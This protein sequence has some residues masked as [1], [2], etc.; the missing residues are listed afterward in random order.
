MDYNKRRKRVRPLL[1]LLAVLLISGMAF[2]AVSVP[3][4]MGQ[5]NATGGVLDLSDADFE[6]TIH[7]LNGEWEFYFGHLY[8]PGNFALGDPEGKALIDVPQTW[9]EQ[10]YPT[11]GFATYR[12]TLRTDEPELMLLVPEIPDA[13]TVFVN[14]RRVF[15]AGMVSDAGATVVSVR[16]ALIPFETEGGVAEIVVQ[17]SNEEW[18][19]SGI[20]YRIETGRPDVLQGDALLRRVVLAGF[21]GIAFAMFLYHMILFLHRRNEKVYLAFAVT[22]LIIVLRFSMETNGLVQMFLPNGMGASLVVLYLSLLPL[23]AAA[24]TLFTHAALR[25]PLKGR[26][27]IA[28]YILTLAVPAVVPFIVPYPGPY[29]YASLIPLA[30]VTVSAVRSKRLHANP[31]NGLYLVAL[32]IFIVWAPLTKRILGDSLFMPG[33]ASNLFLILSQCVMLSIGYTEAKRRDEELVERNALLDNLNRMKDEFLQN[34]SH[35]MKTPLTVIST[36]VINADDLLDFDGDK[37]ALRINLRSAQAEVMR[38][39]RMVDSAME[40]SSAK[41]SRQMLE[42]L[43]IAML[44]RADAQTYHYLLERHGNVLSLEIPDALPPVYG[45]ADT[46][47]QVLSNLLSNAN[48]HTENGGISV[49]VTEREGAVEVTVRDNGEGVAPEVL[50]H[51]FE[52]GVSTEG[53][54]FGLFICKSIMDAHGGRISLENNPRGGACA[55]FVLPTYTENTEVNT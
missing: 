9:S 55:T 23:H 33:V 46:L 45:N 22:C 52:R 18:I 53:T 17:A 49:I 15:T 8:A 3:R 4:H 30:M 50:P 25:L 6:R 26:V 5:T 14:G 20:S 48:R 10:G 31:Y 42:A 28:T 35:E 44:I 34:I 12:L 13:S 37:T 21:L 2:Y 51:V 32:V 19:E 47:S 11:A 24:I 29:I 16:N 54:G 40:F 1:T 7:P 36:N 43:D 38:M 41:E 27:R 39:A